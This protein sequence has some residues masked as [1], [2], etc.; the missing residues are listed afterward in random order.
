MLGQKF[1]KRVSDGVWKIEKG[2]LDSMTVH[3]P[4]YNEVISLFYDY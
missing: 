1:D 4:F 2:V 3:I